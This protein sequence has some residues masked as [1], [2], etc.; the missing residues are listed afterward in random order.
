MDEDSLVWFTYIVRC[1]WLS[2]VYSVNLLTSIVNYSVYFAKRH[3]D[4]LYLTAV[5]SYGFSNR[6]LGSWK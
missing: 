5:G 2:S 3:D 6:A 4:D 1:L